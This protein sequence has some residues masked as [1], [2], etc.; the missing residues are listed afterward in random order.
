[1]TK[2][3]P[4]DPCP[5]GSGKKYKKCCGSPDAVY[6]RELNEVMVEIHRR[7]TQLAREGSVEDIENFVASILDAFPDTPEVVRRAAEL[8]EMRGRFAEALECYRR[9][10]RLRGGGAQDPTVRDKINELETRLARPG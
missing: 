1:M 4:N 8:N 2:V 5:C 10:D 9:L 6:T 7:F 3:R